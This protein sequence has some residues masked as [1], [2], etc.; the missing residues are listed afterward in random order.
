MLKPR[1]PDE[2]LRARL[3]RY[4]EKHPRYGYRRAEAILRAEGYRINDKRVHRLWKELELQVPQRRKTWRR[5][6]EASNGCHQLKA[7]RPNHV[8]AYDFLSDQ[9]VCGKTL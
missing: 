3:R 9:T 2:A 8:W 5:A 1:E 4:A 7:E 6:G